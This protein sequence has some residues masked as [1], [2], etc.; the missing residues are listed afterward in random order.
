MVFESAS[1]SYTSVAALDSSKAVVT[2]TDNG[3]SSYGTA[4]V[5]SISGTT[6][7]AGTPVVFESATTNY[8][9]VAA[10]DSSKA[11]VTYMDAGNSNYGT[12]CVL[13]NM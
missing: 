10:L 9:S 6:V 1:T 3:N 5:L 11:V 13:S 8:I 2:Y 4:C 12:A 7:T